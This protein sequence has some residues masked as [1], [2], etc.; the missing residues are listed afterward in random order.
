MLRRLQTLRHCGAVAARGPACAAQM[1][2]KAPLLQ[3]RYAHR[4]TARMV[5]FA[6]GQNS[7]ECCSPAGPSCVGPANEER[8]ESRYGTMTAVSTAPVATSTASASRWAQ[9]IIVIICMVMIANLQ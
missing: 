1:R 3:I 4:N 6:R 7:F 5:I 9:L 8:L 2:R